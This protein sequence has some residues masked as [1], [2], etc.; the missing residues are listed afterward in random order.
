MPRILKF[1]LPISPGSHGLSLPKVIVPRL[2]DVQEGRPYLWAECD[3]VDYAKVVSVA[4]TGHD[5]PGG[6]YIGTALLDEGRYVLH[7]YL[8]GFA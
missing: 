4:Y 2:I 6:N 1:E 7:Y 5:R 8:E 3:G